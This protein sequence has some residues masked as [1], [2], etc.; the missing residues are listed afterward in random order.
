MPCLLKLVSQVHDRDF[1]ELEHALSMDSSQI[2]KRSAEM[3][4]LKLV[5]AVLQENLPFAEQILSALVK[6]MSSKSKERVDTLTEFY[7]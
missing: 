1:E 3:K 4:C 7:K 5:S 6:R 2:K